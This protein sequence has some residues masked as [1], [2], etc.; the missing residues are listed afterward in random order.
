MNTTKKILFAFTIV[1]TILGACKKEDTKPV[2]TNTE[3]TPPPPF[4]F[5]KVGN[6]WTYNT[7]TDLFWPDGSPQN[8]YTFRTLE[9]VQSDLGN[10]QF[11]I[12]S[13]LTAVGSDTAREKTIWHKDNEAWSKIDSTGKKTT[14]MKATSVKGD[15]T[16][17]LLDG[18][19]G[20]DTVF[21][22]VLSTNETVIVPAGSFECIKQYTY[23]SYSK[24]NANKY[25]LIT[26]YNLKYG[27]IKSELNI[28]ISGTKLFDKKE[29]ISKNF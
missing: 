26:F 27:L 1:T 14:L 18:W 15:I 10:G 11:N 23:D 17:Y 9:S 28:T 7:N 8:S 24:N 12:S 25:S 22:E 4:G 29:L 16:F 13:V 21:T 3:T 19:N 20:V 5:I 2:T 6:S